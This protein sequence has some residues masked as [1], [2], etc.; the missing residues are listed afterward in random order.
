MIEVLDA[1]DRVNGGKVRREM[2]PRRAGDPP[3]LVA[4]NAAL[5][6]TL[7]WRPAH[8]DIDGIVADALAW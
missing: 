2:G 1:V 6:S 4:A 3:K 7:E 8:A 5:L